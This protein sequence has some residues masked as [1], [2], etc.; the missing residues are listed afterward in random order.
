VR[1]HRVLYVANHNQKSSNDDEG[2]ITYALRQLGHEVITEPE[3]TS[4][5]RIAQLSKDCDF[6]LFHKW[7]DTH[8]MAA[9]R[10]PNVM[11][12]FDLVDFPDPGLRRRCVDRIRWMLKVLPHVA[13]GFATDGDWVR[14]NTKKLRWLPQGAD[15]RMLADPTKI[16]FPDQPKILLA[17]SSRGGEKRDSFIEHMRTWHADRLVY[18]PQG[19]Y[20][21]KMRDLVAQCGVVVC[22]D[23]PVTSRYW[24]NRVYNMTGFGGLVFHPRCERLNDHFDDDEV[25]SYTSREE[26][27]EFLKYPFDSMWYQDNMQLMKCGLLRTIE[28]HT[29]R[30]RVMEM[31][32]C[33]EI[34]GIV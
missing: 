19:V 18:V 16:R 9:S 20:R 33:L 29:Y 3:K 24:S 1:K 2:A 25:L 21:E 34:E 13:L 26:L 8:S 31:L 17:A 7:Q 4:L 28:C 14:R 23:G 27:D 32:S 5:P 6:L 10:C 22:P 30:H 11:W 15:E 12:Y